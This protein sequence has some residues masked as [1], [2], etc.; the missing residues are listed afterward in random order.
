MLKLVLLVVVVLHCCRRLEFLDL[1]NKVWKQWLTAVSDINNGY[2]S[3]C[4]KLFL[5]DIK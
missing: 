3:C 5:H 2:S 1:S 4:S